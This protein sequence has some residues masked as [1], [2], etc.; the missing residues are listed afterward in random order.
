MNE[1]LAHA[2]IAEWNVL[3]VIA[4]SNNLMP[5]DSLAVHGDPFG[6]V[7]DFDIVA[8]IANPDL[9]ARIEPRH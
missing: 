7:A 8:L 6:S 3:V 9:F 4:L 2:L 5:T 1:R